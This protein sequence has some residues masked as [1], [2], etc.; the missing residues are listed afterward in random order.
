MKLSLAESY[1]DAVPVPAGIVMSSAM[2]PALVELPRARYGETRSPNYVAI[3][4]TAALHAAALAAILYV[5]Y[6]APPAQKEEKLVVVDLTPP[7]PQPAPDTPPSPPQIV[8]PAPPIAVP[9]PVMVAATPEPVPHDLP[10]IAAP[11]PAPAPPAPP[12]PPSVVTG[13]DLSARMIAGAPPRY[14]IECRRKKEQ[15]TV[16]LALT[17]GVDGRVASISIARSSGHERLDDAAL[18]AVRKWRWQPLVKDGKPV[19]V[20]GQVEIPFVLTA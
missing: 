18:S 6:E 4:I 20:K 7:P 3:I 10:P 16:V 5:R 19:M 17:L 1:D 9:R 14:P 11:A 12:A 13:A 2:A 15:G 8:A